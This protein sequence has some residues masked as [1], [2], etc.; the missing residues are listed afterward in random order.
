M[1]NILM[2]SFL[3]LACQEQKQETI[4]DQNC[5]N[6]KEQRRL[7][8]ELERKEQLRI[9]QE[10]KEIQKEIERKSLP[11]NTCSVVICNKISRFSL[12]V[13]SHI[14]DKMGETCFDAIIPKEQANVGSILNSESRWYQGKSINPTKKSITKIKQVNMCNSQ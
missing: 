14:K 10:Q 9:Q 12:N 3:L 6:E 5:L 4:C 1:K 11:L 13:V 2:L 7:N 8:I